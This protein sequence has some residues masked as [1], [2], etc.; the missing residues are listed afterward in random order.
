M[1]YRQPSWMLVAGA[2]LLAACHAKPRLEHTVYYGSTAVYRLKPGAQEITPDKA[3][4]SF[5]SQRF[6]FHPRFNQPLHRVVRNSG[7]ETVYLGLVMPPVPG[8][9]TVLTLPDSVWQLVDARSASPHAGRL[10]LLRNAR[11]GEYNVRY[12]NKI[13]ATSNVHIIN[14]LTSDSLLAKRYYAAD[15]LFEGNLLL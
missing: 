4:T 2:G 6:N 7:T 8:D 9:L 15:S 14:L 1:F 12:V 10:A 11:R 13:A 3:T 5:Y